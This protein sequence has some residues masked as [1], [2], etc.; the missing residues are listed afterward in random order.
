MK[1]SVQKEVEELIK[2]FNL[3]CSVKQFKYKV[4]WNRISC[5]QN[6]SEDFIREFQDKVD[7]GCIPYQQKLSENLIK[8][9]QDKV[10][11]DSISSYQK[12]SENFIV[13]F[14][15]RLDIH[16]ILERE[17]LKISEEIRNYLKLLA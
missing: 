15:N 2:I 1:P 6:L 17:D 10:D 16:V 8:A 4:D 7:W 5:Y 11:W 13:E 12:L 14:A 3:N 9:F